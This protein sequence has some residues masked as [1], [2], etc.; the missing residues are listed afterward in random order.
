MSIFIVIFIICLVSILDN[1]SNDRR[2]MAGS[3]RNQIIDE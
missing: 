2:E 1:T 3:T